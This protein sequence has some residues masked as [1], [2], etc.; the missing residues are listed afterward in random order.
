MGRKRDAVDESPGA[1][2]VGEIGELAHR[3][4]AADEVRAVRECDQLGAR[5]EQRLEVPALEFRGLG[6][7]LPLA[8]RDAVLGQAGPG[9]YVRLVVLVGDNHLVA[10]LQAA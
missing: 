2:A 7:D 10:L 4:D 6:I 8:Y 5:S 9:A 1:G 3:V